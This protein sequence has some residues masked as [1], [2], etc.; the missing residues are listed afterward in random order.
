MSMRSWRYTHGNTHGGIGVV[1]APVCTNAMANVYIDW[2]C[3]TQVLQTIPVC[4]QTGSYS[5]LTPFYTPSS[6]FRFKNSKFS[7]SLFFIHDANFLSLPFGQERDLERVMLISE[8]FRERHAYTV[9]QKTRDVV[10]ET[11]V[12]VSR[13]L[14][15]DFLRSWSWSREARS[16]SWS[17]SW[18]VGLEN[19]QDQLCMS[20]CNSILLSVIQKNSQ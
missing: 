4:S 16:W 18:R 3:Y 19:F 12:L 1:Y 14:E 17:R 13:A 6:S 20:L 8:G 9:A 7:T 10:L 15:T 11:S 2:K 5:T